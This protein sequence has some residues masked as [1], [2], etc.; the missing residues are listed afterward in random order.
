[1]ALLDQSVKVFFA[2]SDKIFLQLYGHKLPVLGFDIS[3]DN[4]MLG[5]HK[6]FLYLS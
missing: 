3:S 4:Q 6:K 2:D 1:V 5:I